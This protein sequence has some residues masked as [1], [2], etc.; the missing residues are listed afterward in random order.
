MGHLL[1]YRLIQIV[2]ERSI[3]FWTIAFP[4][5]L[6][7]FFFMAFGDLAKHETIA[8]QI[9]VAIVAKEVTPQTTAQKNFLQQMVQEKWLEI[10]SFDSE[11]I[12]KQKLADDKIAGIFDL[13]PNLSLKVAKSDFNTSIL[14]EILDGYNRN[15]AMLTEI[16]Q[17]HPDQLAA[18]MSS[19][20]TLKPAVKAVAPNGKSTSSF[21]QYFFTLIAYACLSGVFLGVKNATDTQANLSPLAAR[22]G[23]TPVPKLTLIIVDFLVILLVDFISVLFLTFYIIKGFGISLG[24]NLTGILLTVL[25][26]CVIGVSMGI[27][28]GAS[29]HA[30]QNIKIALTVLLSLFPSFLAGLMFQDMTAVIEQYAPIVN[31]LNPAAVL[32]DAFYCLS[33]YDNPTRYARDMWTL[34]AMS[35]VCL[36]V[37]FSLSRRERYDSI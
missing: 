19:L 29:N 31:R 23:I 12:A 24:D 30:S 27:V 21:L 11:T 14:K 22:R 8:T 17:S 10:R 16:S 32:S 7:T 33:V 36:A 34:L 20:K 37:A 6:G 26:G 3:L 13:G 1:K 2:R 18:A 28:L 35:L 4:M 9:P 5:I 15:A 25:M